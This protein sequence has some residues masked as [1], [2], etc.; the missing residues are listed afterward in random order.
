MNQKGKKYVDNRFTL[1]ALWFTGL[2]ISLLILAWM[3]TGGPTSAAEMQEANITKTALAMTASYLLQP[4]L[5]PPPAFTPTALP[6]TMI[7]R[8]ASTLA[9]M[10]S[11]TSPSL[12]QQ[13]NTPNSTGV[14]LITPLPTE[15]AVAQM[16]TLTSVQ[17]PAGFAHWYFARVWNERDYQNLWENYLT[18][19]Y[20]INVGSGIFEDYVIWWESVAWVEVHSVDVLQ[21]N[22][23]DAWV[24]VNVTFHMK[25]GRAVQDQIY[26]YDLLYDPLRATWMFD[27]S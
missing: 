23:M 9:A 11:A 10:L 24:R 15:T 14:P 20:K 4:R 26:D 3:V 6:P 27:A 8:S 17:D 13:S 5:Q 22:G 19:S 21:N 7:P 25:D 1:Q 18:P 2:F 12:S 16:P